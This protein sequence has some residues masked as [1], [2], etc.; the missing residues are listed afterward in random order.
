MRAK[1]LTLNTSFG[2]RDL[3]NDI[4]LLIEES[5]H[6]VAATVNAAMTMLYWRIGKRI[7]EDILKGK[8]ADYGKQIIATLSQQLSQE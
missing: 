8:R 5:R 2:G 6:A 7:N 1:T 4:R 3:H